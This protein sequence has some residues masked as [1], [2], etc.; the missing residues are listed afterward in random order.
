[1]CFVIRFGVLLVLLAALG[2]LAL[3]QQTTAAP[4]TV[5]RVTV[6][7]V[8]VDA[9][10]TDSKGRQVTNLTRD[11][12]EIF[13]NNRPQQITHF[14][15]IAANS[16]SPA[17]PAGM[18][19]QFG[20][21]TV[22]LRPEQVRR[23]IALVVDDL[24]MSWESTHPVRILLR[25]FVDEQMQPGDLVAVVRTSAGMGSLQRFTSDKRL[26]HAAIDRLRWLPRRGSAS[27]FLP[28]FGQLAGPRE[29]R[30]VP[31]AAKANRQIARQASAAVREQL[32]DIEESIK[33]SFTVGSLGALEHVVEGLRE[34]PGRKA[35]IFFSDGLSLAMR[36]R[37][38]FQLLDLFR[39]L[40]DQA[41]RASV[42]V[43]AMDARGLLPPDFGPAD[44]VGAEAVARLERALEKQ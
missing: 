16:P 4:E 2:R 26:L 31:E 39:R 19:A 17:A 29:A 5:F 7:L 10:V 38:R 41:N 25:K 12:F 6:N 20:G 8:Q 33:L 40:V 13:D 32:A 28:R 35:A 27:A 14:A 9:V 3:A 11:D 18:P 37:T 15:Y 42:L 23:S 30:S 36:G 22:P 44:Q 24:G 43:Y 21:L 34:L 1:M